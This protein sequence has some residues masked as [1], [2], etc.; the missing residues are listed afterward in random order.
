MSGIP[1]HG[2]A[3]SRKAEGSLITF[4]L[5]LCLTT[6][7]ILKQPRRHIC[8]GLTIRYN[9]LSKPKRCHHVEE[10]G[11]LEEEVAVVEEEVVEEAK[12][13]A[14]LDLIDD[15]M[16]HDLQRTMGK[17]KYDNVLK[18]YGLLTYHAFFRLESSGSESESAPEDTVMEDLESEDE[19]DDEET[20]SAKPYMALLQSFNNE[21]NAPNSKRR[22]LDHKES[23]Q[24]QPGEDSSSDEEGEEGQ[25]DPEKDIDR[26][27]DEA[28]DQV[29]EQVDDDD[30]S[31]DEENPTDP[32]DVHF[33]HPDEDI[34]AKRVKSA[35]EGN[36][37]T[38][39]ALIQ[40]LRATVTYPASDAGSEV[41]KPIAGL[42][43]LQLKQKLKEISSRKIGEFSAVQRNLSPLIFNYNDVLFCDRTVRNSDSLRELTCLHALNHVFK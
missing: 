19:D 36:W 8:C 16:A 21:S 33:A 38:K 34:V 24:S 17:F 40:T 1:H 3:F 28:E 43:G 15:L 42:D 9:F 5:Q 27:E 4:F 29:E 6:R 7:T 18:F 12:R 31:E 25:D 23:A 39:R 10:E 13:Q 37:A 14:D 26:A 41:P 2:V 32:F 35:Q 20:A 30:D 11:I 22:K